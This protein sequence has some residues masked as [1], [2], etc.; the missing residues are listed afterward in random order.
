MSNAERIY[1]IGDIHGQFAKL[2]G[3]LRNAELVDDRLSWTGGATNLWFMG[4]FFD[5]GPDGIA[6]VDLV[7]RLQQ[8]AQVAGGR[9]ESLLGNHE[10]L[11]LAAQRFGEQTS[12]GQGGTFLASWKYNG[13]QDAD[14]AKLTTRHIEWVTSLPAMAHVG[15]WLFV[16]ADATFYTSYGSSVESVN[17]AFKAILQSNNAVAFDQILDAFAAR[18]EFEDKHADGTE[19]AVQFL[20]TFGGQRLIHGHT[21]IRD[22]QPVNAPRIYANGLCTNVDGGMYTGNPGFLYELPQEL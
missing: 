12:G 4:D 21:P 6:A 5:R 22:T 9:V 20:R 19:R 11:I 3:L 14:L 8:E 18:R 10:V 13:G 2:A 7:M 15:E 16:H 1:V 17:Q